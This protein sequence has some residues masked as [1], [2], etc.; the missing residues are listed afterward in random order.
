MVVVAVAAVVANLCVA[1]LVVAMTNSSRSSR[2]ENFRFVVARSCCGWWL[3]VGVGD[4]SV[5]E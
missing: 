5:H 1:S 2:C 3:M 4:L